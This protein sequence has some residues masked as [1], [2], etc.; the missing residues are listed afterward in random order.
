VG[1][2][3]KKLQWLFI[4]FLSV[5]SICYSAFMLFNWPRPSR[6]KQHEEEKRKEQMEVETFLNA[7]KPLIVTMSNNN[8]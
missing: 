8:R 4:I 7:S 3:K 2:T 5:A 6:E 1:A